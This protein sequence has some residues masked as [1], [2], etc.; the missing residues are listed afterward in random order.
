MSTETLV[1]ATG[2]LATFVASVLAD[3]QQQRLRNG[4]LG[5]LAGSA[6]GALAS[7][8]TK[9]DTLL[10]AGAFGST[11]GAA[12]GWIVYLA[13][14]FIASREWGKRL[15]EYHVHGLRGVHERILSDEKALLLQALNYWG[16]NFSRAVGI[17]RDRVLD[18]ARTENCNYWIRLMILG[19][20][21]TA[22]DTFNL[23]LDTVASQ[24]KYRSRATVL[25]FGRTANDEIVGRHWCSYSGRLPAHRR[26]PFDSTSY[27]YGVLTGSLPS[28]FFTNSDLANRE[29]Q[30][31][32]GGRYY[33]FVVLRINEHAVLSVD[34]P[35]EL[36]E[37]DPQMR[38]VRDL[39]Y[40]EVVPA[41]IDVLAC[42]RGSL[43][44]EVSLS[45]LTD[46]TNPPLAL[47][48]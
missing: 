11:V 16:G 42:W 21:T 2:L 1:F 34:W 17:E 12:T 31:R 20:L 43:A 37:T 39:F 9:D 41:I 46:T 22:V 23:V 35:E 15:V 47:D 33:S 6:I 30:Q 38:I 32:S 26:D 4:T 45:S 10:V 25:V 48:S 36:E 28:P 3:E 8:I 29:A 14:A 27:A 5:A 44:A 13:L 24:H 7:L 40:L 18:K 19:W